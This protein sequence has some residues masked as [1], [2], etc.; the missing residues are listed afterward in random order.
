MRRLVLW[1]LTA[2]SAD[3]TLAVASL[4]LQSHALHVAVHGPDA[5]RATETQEAA[6]AATSP[7]LF[8]RVVQDGESCG[9]SASEVPMCASRDYVCRME[10]GKEM[11]ANAPSCL[12]YEPDKM[13]DDPYAEETSS[14]APWDFCDPQTAGVQ[15]ICQREFQC[16]C[17]ETSTACQCVPPDIVPDDQR[18][19]E[20]GDGALKC[21]ENDGDCADGEYCKFTVSGEQQCG[22]KPYYS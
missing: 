3:A 20:G 17:W 9:S 8:T 18:E 13:R 10:V 6:A 22:Q 12:L 19:A 2:L 14:A 5:A 1:T 21:G 4:T 11:F 16:Q 15:P 7:M